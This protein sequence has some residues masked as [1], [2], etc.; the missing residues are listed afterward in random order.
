[1]YCC[2]HWQILKGPRASPDENPCCQYQGLEND[3]ED[4]VALHLKNPEHDQLQASG[5]DGLTCQVGGYCTGASLCSGIHSVLSAVDVQRNQIGYMEHAAFPDCMHRKCQ[6]FLQWQFL[7]FL[8][9]ASVPHLRLQIKHRK[10][11]IYYAQIVIIKKLCWKKYH[12]AWRKEMTPSF[13]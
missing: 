8:L 12:Q 5:H 3:Q 10:N 13:W 1:M 9:L 11:D 6:L 7:A 2:F 4:P